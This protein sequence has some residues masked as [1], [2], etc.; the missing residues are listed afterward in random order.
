MYPSLPNSQQQAMQ[1]ICYTLGAIND[2]L[3]LWRYTQSIGDIV[4]KFEP[5]PKFVEGSKFG[6][7]YLSGKDLSGTLCFKVNK[8]TD[9]YDD[10]DW[11]SLHAMHLVLSKDLYNSAYGFAE[12]IEQ[13][14]YGQETEFKWEKGSSFGTTGRITTRDN[15]ARA[16]FEKKLFGDRVLYFEKIK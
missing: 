3:A 2:E 10:E 14:L 9:K 4:D 1:L 7:I 13:G 16:V 15:K 5:D 8:S 11:L 6:N 12:R